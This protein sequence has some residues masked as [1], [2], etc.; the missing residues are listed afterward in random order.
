[1]DDTQKNI[2]ASVLLSEL[3]KASQDMGQVIKS[4]QDIAKQTNLLS[5]NSAIEAARAGEAGRGF[6]V[7]ADEIKKLAIRSFDS[8]KKS[9]TIISNIVGQANEVMGIR[10][11]DVA[12]DVMDKIDRNLF[13]RNCD[14]QAWATFEKARNCLEQSDQQTL[15]DCRMFL[16]NLVDIYEVYLDL[17]I[18]DVNGNIIASGVNTNLIGESLANDDWFKQAK[19]VNSISVSDLFFSKI[20]NKPTIAYTCP[21]RSTNGSILG[22]FSSRF[23]WNYIYDIID[24]A[25]IGKNG[26]IYIINQQG[27]VIATKD[28]QDILKTNLNHL[29]GVQKA[30]SGIYYGYSL[31]TDQ[32]G[33]TKII[34]Y[35]HTHG[36][37]AYKG[38]NW[39]AIVTETL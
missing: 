1:M 12:Y 4:I 35:A 34:G 19:A 33:S 15:S 6:G 38:K 8:T 3:K 17:F 29:D 16:K 26:Q 37:N 22:Y 32:I 11:A 21:I 18:L 25:K 30:M 39:S 9:D 5:L 2:D 13:E 7:V 27:M 24:S 10:T 23:N 20:S 28:R 14:V 31:T 36:Y